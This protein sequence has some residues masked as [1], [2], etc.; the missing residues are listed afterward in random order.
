MEIESLDEGKLMVGSNV[1]RY[2]QRHKHQN[3]SENRVMRS[4]LDD[5]SVKLSGVKDPK[6]KI[7]NISEIL[8][9]MESHSFNKK[10]FKSTEMLLQEIKKPSTKKQSKRK[11][12]D[13]ETEK[14]KTL[15]EI[16]TGRANNLEQTLK[17]LQ[18]DVETTKQNILALENQLLTKDQI[19]ESLLLDRV[20]SKDFQEVC[21]ANQ[22]LAEEINEKNVLLKECEDLIAEFVRKQEN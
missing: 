16:E 6:K 3:L 21:L 12:V 14:I 17:L 1:K 22:K 11:S 5:T 8:G 9:V 18:Q 10:T 7:S 15:L 4:D 2:T 13:K 19:I 20:P